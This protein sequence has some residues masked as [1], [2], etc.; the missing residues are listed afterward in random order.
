MDNYIKFLGTGGAR[1][2]VARQLRHSGGVYLHL[3]GK[4]IIMDPG[5]GTLVRCAA[6]RPPIDV[7]GLD[8][9]ILTHAHIDHSNDVNILIDGMTEGGFK[10]R[11][12]LFAPGECL[13]GENA[14]VLK[15]LRPFLER[16]EILSAGRNY[17]L[18]GVRFSTSVRH[19]HP[20]ETYGII[21]DLDGVRLSFLVDTL[22]F[23]E[24]IESYRGTDVLVINIVRYETLK[25]GIMHLDI[26]DVTGILQEIRPKKAV[27]THFGMTMLRAKP[28]DV[29]AALARETGIEVI[30]ASDGMK[31]PV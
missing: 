30:A 20:A 14:V 12:T 8:A 1:F 3:K 23:K 5:P 18:D 9:L 7:A 29:A 11:G 28:R 25:P 27:L 6:S 15:Y 24:L 19:K 4:K 10:K 17:E 26:G 31:I 21:F 16:I 22:F 2:V 13:E